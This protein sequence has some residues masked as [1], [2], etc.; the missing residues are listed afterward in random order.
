MAFDSE[1]A[2][3]EKNQQRHKQE[4]PQPRRNLSGSTD[5]GS[6]PC[7]RSLAGSSGPRS[8]HL[9]GCRIPRGLGRFQHMDPNG[10]LLQRGIRKS[11]PLAFSYYESAAWY[12]THL[13]TKS[14]VPWPHEGRGCTGDSTRHSN[15]HVRLCRLLNLKPA[16]TTRFGVCAAR[17]LP[18]QTR[19]AA[20]RSARSLHRAHHW[21]RPHDSGHASS[22]S[23]AELRPRRAPAAV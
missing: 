7:V 11:A 16:P 15:L 19:S 21:K 20:R 8:L 5:R 9:G 13:Q 22:K 3:H 12:T 17:T 1:R 18:W 14:L 23:C 6:L 10:S 2:C 4:N